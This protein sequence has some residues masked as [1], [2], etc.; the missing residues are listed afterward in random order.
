M[1][2]RKE[3]ILFTAREII[4]KQGVD[5]LT[6]RYLEKKKPRDEPDNNN[7]FIQTWAIIH[8]LIMLVKQKVVKYHTEL[9]AN[10]LAYL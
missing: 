10:R 2:K 8:G 6:M 1:N 7:L 5:K 9:A 4:E 3:Q